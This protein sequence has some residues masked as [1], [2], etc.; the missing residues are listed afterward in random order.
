M[1][2]S[3]QNYTFSKRVL[4]NSFNRAA[5]SYDSSAI[6]QNEVGSRLIE[7][8]E[9]V[10]IEPQRIVDLGSG[11][12]IFTAQLQAQYKK[13][14]LLGIDL[15]WQMSALAKSKN[16]WLSKQ[17]F[18][19]AD[20]ES[21]PLADNSVELVFSNL[22]LHWIS[23]PD[24]LF[25]E[26][27]RVLVPGG[28]LMFTG[29]GP[30]TLKEMR[31]SWLQVDDNVHVNRFLDM[32][33]VGDSL[34]NNGF[35]GA[36]MDNET[37]T[38]TYENISQLH[39]DLHNLGEVNRNSGRNPCLTGKSRWND[40]LQAYQQ[41]RTSEGLFPASWEVVYG[42]AWARQDLLPT[43]KSGHDDPLLIKKSSINQM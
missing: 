1:D 12:G 36:V 34:T 6:L 38:M 32:H 28:L 11:T 15:A 3:N 8:L 23:N 37:I 10:K 19:C 22:M 18:I 35:E 20:A 9:L 17:R 24:R 4:A 31:Q 7:R 43:Q 30:D 14:K 42:H 41:H 13:A 25:R 39:Q 21:L 5:N 2:N 26:I 16:R 27:H 40:Y 29:F 33:D